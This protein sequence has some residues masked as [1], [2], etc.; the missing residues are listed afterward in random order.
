MVATEQRKKGGPIILTAEVSTKLAAVLH[1]G[2]QPLNVWGATKCQSSL[3]HAW[4]TTDR[5]GA[6]DVY[7]WLEEEGH[8]KRY[9]IIKA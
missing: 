4:S 7:K 3:A 5:E 9:N 1:L 2:G 6:I 8:R